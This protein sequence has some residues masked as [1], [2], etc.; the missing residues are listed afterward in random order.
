M[1]FLIPFKYLSLL[2]II[3]NHPIG[4]ILDLVVQDPFQNLDPSSLSDYIHAK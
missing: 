1:L 2:F 4:N 3:M